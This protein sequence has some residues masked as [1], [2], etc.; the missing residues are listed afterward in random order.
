MR[1]IARSKILIRFI[2]THAE[3]DVIDA[4]NI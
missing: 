2:G 3:Y 1:I 4:K